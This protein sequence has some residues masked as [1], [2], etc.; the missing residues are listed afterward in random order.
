MEAHQKNL[1]PGEAGR[2]PECDGRLEAVA[3]GVALVN[4]RVGSS[5]GGPASVEVICHWW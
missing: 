4:G 3:V 1:A 5:G 2:D